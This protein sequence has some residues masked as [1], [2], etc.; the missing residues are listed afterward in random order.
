MRSFQ[1]VSVFYKIRA[2]N[3][4][5]RKTSDEESKTNDEIRTTSDE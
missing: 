4:E 1:L 2:T 5:R 3:D